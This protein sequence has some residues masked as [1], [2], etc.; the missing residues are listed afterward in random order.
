MWTPFQT[1]LDQ[2]RGIRGPVSLLHSWHWVLSAHERLFIT[3]KRVAGVPRREPF[4]GEVSPKVEQFHQN[5]S[6]IIC[7]WGRVIQWHNVPIHL[8]LANWNVMCRNDTWL[9]NV[10]LGK[11]LLDIT[12]FLKCY[13]IILNIL[14]R[15]YYA[16]DRTFILSS[17]LGNIHSW[18]VP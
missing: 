3:F 17:F 7:E 6:R 8:R 9:G 10:V 11:K 13:D 16:T 1:T 5:V 4:M 14:M 12:Y 18:N 15:R 2:E